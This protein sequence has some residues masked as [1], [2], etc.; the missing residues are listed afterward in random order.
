[1]EPILA[2]VFDFDD[3]LAPDS[4]SGLMRLV[5]FEPKAFWSGE[6]EAMLAEGW[7][8]VPG[9]M[10]KLIELSEQQ[11][12]LITADFLADWGR[13]LPLFEGV[14]EV[15]GL[16][17]EYMAQAAPGFRLEFY[18]ISSGIGQILRHTAI[19]PEFTEI[20][21]SDFSYNAAQAIAF[22]KRV[23][24][25][26]DKTRYLFQISKGIIGAKAKDSTLV[27]QRF[28]SFRIPM[29]QILFVGDGYTD[30]PCFSLLARKGGEAI[31][32]Y[33]KERPETW[34]KAR[35]FVKDERV[36]MF[37]R[38]DY[39]P[40]SPLLDSLKGLLVEMAERAGG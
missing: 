4:T 9:F 40:D 33:Q 2:V 31:A 30:I 10:H 21:A 11:G 23:V 39:R 7:D 22:P 37:E 27:N 13:R 17:R 3:T 35:G 12:G 19:A 25:F 14:T 16:L 34:K 28:E 36:K 8:Q 5:G 24:S 26:T 18:L 29:H 6:F 38:A 1:M 15:F 20:W 32:V